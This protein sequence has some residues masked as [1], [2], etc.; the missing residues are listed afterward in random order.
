MKRHEKRHVKHNISH[1]L[2]RI[3]CLV[4]KVVWSTTRA[5][6]ICFLFC[7]VKDMSV[8]TCVW[9]WIT[10]WKTNVSSSSIFSLF[11]L[12]TKNKKEW[13]LLK[14]SYTLFLIKHI[15]TSLKP[16]KLKEDEWCH[17]TEIG[18]TKVLI[19]MVSLHTTCELNVK[20]KQ[21]L[22]IWVVS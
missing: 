18:V 20:Y 9:I 22:N 7:P 17:A 21:T 11:F 19:I 6:E 16:C 4:H 15:H 2:S 10:H 14:D 8:L 12:E 13:P 3:V 5:Y 1:I